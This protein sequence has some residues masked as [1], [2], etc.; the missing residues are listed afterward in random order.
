[1][2]TPSPTAAAPAKAR[3]RLLPWAG[4]LL[5]ACGMAILL[6]GLPH[7]PSASGG[8]TIDV[9]AQLGANHPTFPKLKTRFPIDGISLYRVA[10]PDG[11]G[12][13]AAQALFR[14]A[15]NRA[16]TAL[17][18]IRRNG[19]ETTPGALPPNW[20][21]ADK[22][23]SLW[24]EAMT[25][26]RERAEPNAQIAG[27]WPNAQ[28]VRLF[29]G[30]AT[31]P[32]WALRSGYGDPHTWPVWSVLSGGFGEDG[33]PQ[34][35]LARCLTQHLSAALP[36]LKAL[37]PADRPAYLI[38]TTDDLGHLDEMR[39]LGGNAV[40]LQ[41]RQFPLGKDIHGTIRRTREWAE[42]IHAAGYLV[43]QADTAAVTVWASTRPVDQEA[44]LIRLLPFSHSLQQTIPQFELLYQ[45]SWG[46]YIS[47]YRW[48]P[49]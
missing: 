45:S 34:R 13:L 43:Q 41:N 18:A 20:L 3:I 9:E 39:T 26:L 16:A 36:C 21:S 5:A 12:I 4:L 19:P 48:R 42:E 49:Q 32:W 15:D 46:G 25:T 11:A 47:I 29:T 38:V 17:L 24:N 14:D 1:M 44:L 23:L 27:W 8:W 2:P 40:T 28:R 31:T 30:L 22:P 35:Q 10:A 7:L 33:K 37:L 6:L